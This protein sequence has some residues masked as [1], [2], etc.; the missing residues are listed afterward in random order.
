MCG[1]LDLGKKA[2]LIPIAVIVITVLCE[3]FKEIIPSEIRTYYGNW[4]RISFFAMVVLA[5]S[6]S[7]FLAIA[8]FFKKQ[9]IIFGVIGFLL[10]L[11]LLAY[12]GLLLV[13]AILFEAASVNSIT[14][15]RMN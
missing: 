6:I 1:N 14:T 5:V 2:F 15:P 9:S 13:L 4:F 12:F 3:S 7:I 10:D 8:S 11:P